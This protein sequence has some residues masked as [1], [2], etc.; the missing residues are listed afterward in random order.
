MNAIEFVVK[1]S[2]IKVVRVPKPTL[3]KKRSPNQPNLLV[4]V[5]ASAIDPSIDK[6][7]PK[8]KLPDGFFVH[9]G[10]S[11]L[12]M[13]WHFSG[14]VEE[15]VGDDCDTPVGT[16]VFGF[17]EY[18]PMQQQG[19]FAEYILVKSTECAVKPDSVNFEL[20]AAASTEAITALQALRNVGRLTS[21]KSVLICGSS[22]GVGSV[23]VR[24]AK[25]LGASKVTAMCSDREVERVRAEFQPDAV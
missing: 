10:A 20:A 1:T 14:I 22:G 9:S 25:L 21:G 12:Y 17:L 19:S 7:F 23:A 16:A 15:T 3:P 24:I 2:E 18:S 11:P 6:K 13:G 4:K 5:V 8:L